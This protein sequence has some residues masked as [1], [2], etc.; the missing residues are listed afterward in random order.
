MLTRRRPRPATIL[1]RPDMTPFMDVAFLL[2]VFFIWLN[3]LQKPNVLSFS[4]PG[5]SWHIPGM[6]PAT[7]M[8]SLILLPKNRVGVFQRWQNDSGIARLLETDYQTLPRLLANLK[9]QNATGRSLILIEPTSQ[10]TFGNLVSVLTTLKRVGGLP[11]LILNKPM[12]FE[13]RLMAHYKRVDFTSRPTR[14]LG[15]RR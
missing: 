10:A 14:V 12:G 13:N 3:W 7:E 8:L 15:F 9:R 1:P 4:Q 5:R 11:Y 6:E 2:I